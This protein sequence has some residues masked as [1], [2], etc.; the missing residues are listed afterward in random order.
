MT[1][2]PHPLLAALAVAATYVYFLIFAEFAFI[3][4]ALKAGLEGDRLQWVMGALALGGITGSVLAAWC[5]NPWRLGRALAI[6]FAVCAVGAAVSALVPAKGFALVAAWCGLGLGWLTVTLASGLRG[7]LG[8]KKLGWWIGAG[9]GLAYAICNLPWVFATDT[10]NQAWL[11]AAV[12]V[13][14]AAL[15]WRWQAEMVEPVRSVDYGRRGLW[16]WLFMLLGL[17]W[18]DSAAFYVIQHVPVLR[19]PT[20]GG[21]AA[22]WIN[23]AMHLVAALAAGWMIDRGW[24]ARVLPLAFGLLWLAC[25]RLGHGLFGGSVLLYTT[26]VSL[27]STILVAYPAR[28]RRPWIAAAVYAIAGWVGSALGI[29]MAQDL[30]TVP[31]W[32]LIFAAALFGTAW[33]WQN[34]AARWLAGLAVVGFFTNQ[35]RADEA[36]LI[37]QGREVYIA[38]GCIHCHSQYVRSG[39]LD[40]GRWGP[41][42][43][44]AESRAG[45]PP[46]LGNRRQGPDLANVGLRRTPEWNRLH[47]V[48][49]QALAPGSRMPAYAYLFRGADSRG[50][51]LVAYLATLGA[52]HAEEAR[53]AQTA[54]QPAPAVVRPAVE[55]RQLFQ[56]L[57]VSCHG[58]AG[59]GDGPL[60]KQ[61][62][63]TPPDFAQGWRRLSPGEI[64]FEMKLARL[65]RFGLSGTPMAG[66]EYLEDRDVLSL[67]AYVQSLHSPS[68]P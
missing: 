37:A 34:R 51:A 23:A 68:H 8:G 41:A 64:D 59:R 22:L 39:T 14:G 10:H 17:V 31:D 48:S 46:L 4:L 47:L 42:V 61:L 58:P 1:S 57:C 6:G 7:L 12:C 3:E 52:E 56:Q 49:P 54:W 35:T 38:E 63:V 50:D 30:H 26:A 18:L 66:H 45:D 53:E 24:M 32:F 43:P 33:L 28:S 29:G 62:A 16:V 9:T 40:V 44:L 25:W 21:S 15:V 36:D 11:A 2:R 20:W 5:F 55:Q 67:A 60:A 13:A 19:E 65:I 27:Y